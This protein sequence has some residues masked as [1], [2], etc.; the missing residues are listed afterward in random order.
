M[1]GICVGPQITYIF[2]GPPGAILKLYTRDPQI[3]TI[4]T[5]FSSNPNQTHLSMLIRVIKIVRKSQI[6]K[7]DQGWS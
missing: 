3:W 2:T 7:F 6:C 1:S 5:E 4:P